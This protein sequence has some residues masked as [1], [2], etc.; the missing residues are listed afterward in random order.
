[1]AISQKLRSS[2]TF[3]SS[4]SPVALENTEGLQT[5]LRQASPASPSVSQAEEPERTTSATC[6]PRQPK[7]FAWYDHDSHF[8]RT[9]Q[10]SL[11]TGTLD[12]FSGT[13]PR[14]GMLSDGQCSE[15]TTLELPTAGR[16]S[17]SL[18]IGTPTAANK[19]RSKAFAKDRTPTPAEMAMLPTPSA[20]SY[21]TN[22]GGSAGRVGPVRPSLEMMARKDLWPTP[23]INGNYN[24]K[25]LS[26]ASGDGLATAVKKWPS[27]AARDYRTGGDLKREGGPSLQHEIGGALNPTWVAWLMGWPLGWESCEPLGI[28]RFRQWLEL[29]GNCSVIA[30]PLDKRPADAQ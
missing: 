26:P 5:W 10:V 27:P 16:G 24:K 15:L 21:G 3:V 28:D 29:H 8:W 7:S 20:T 30:R 12:E 6:G 2:E 9:Y 23:T 4:S 11:L 22:Q 19:K 14:S 17:G 1:M 25:G 18:R 13:W